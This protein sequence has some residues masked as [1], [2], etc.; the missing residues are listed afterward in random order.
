MVKALIRKKRYDSNAALQSAIGGRSGL[1][2]GYNIM[3]KYCHACN[4]IRQKGNVPTEAAKALHDCRENHFGKSSKSMEATAA[5]MLQRQLHERFVTT[6]SQT[7]R[8]LSAIMDPVISDDDAASRAQL[9]PLDPTGNDIVGRGPMW[10]GEIRT[11]CD[12]NHRVKCFTGPLYASGTN[13]KTITYARKT[14]GWALKQGSKDDLETMRNQMACAKDHM[15][16]KHDNCEKFFPGYCHALHQKDGMDHRPALPYG[17]YFTDGLPVAVETS[18]DRITTDAM[19]EQCL[20]PYHTQGNEAC[21]NSFTNCE[22][23]KSRCQYVGTPIHD[24]RAGIFALRH[25]TGF[26]GLLHTLEQS[27]VQITKEQ[28]EV[29]TVIERRKDNRKE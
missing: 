5:V 27:G 29:A 15:C 1:L 11:L 25:T 6:C 3:Q 14:F 10:I 2:L 9:R 26:R 16:G 7:G 21:N 19:L 18:W 22:Q 20:H 17:K 12:P 4:A 23:P 24:F 13:R 28:L 8:V